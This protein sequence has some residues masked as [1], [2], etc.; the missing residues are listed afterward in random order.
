MARQTPQERKAREEAG[1]R[2][3]AESR[4][5]LLGMAGALVRTGQY[6]QAISEYLELIRAH[7]NSAEAVESESALLEL[8]ENYKKLGRAHKALG[9]YKMLDG[10]P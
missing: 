5:S 7:P 8:A 1:S 2:I 6:N 3:A 4:S 10:L 9:L